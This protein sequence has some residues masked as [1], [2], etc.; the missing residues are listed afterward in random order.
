MHYDEPQRIDTS[1]LNSLFVLFTLHLNESERLCAHIYFSVCKVISWYKYWAKPNY[2][3]LGLS[4]RSSQAKW[5]VF[6]WSLWDECIGYLRHIERV[7]L[8]WYVWRK[9]SL[10]SPFCVRTRCNCIWFYM[11]FISFSL[12]RCRYW[13][14]I[15]RQKTLLC[16]SLHFLIFFLF[17]VL[18]IFFLLQNFLLMSSTS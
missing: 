11:S 16:M 8:Q 12:N 13:S 1:T 2:A 14:I 7:H 6:S 4:W 15:L 9:L 10:G 17:S 3:S 5:Y 18:L